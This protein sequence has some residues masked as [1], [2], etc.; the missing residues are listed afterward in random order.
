MVGPHPLA[1]EAGGLEREELAFL[2]ASQVMLLLPLSDIHTSRATAEDYLNTW[3]ETRRQPNKQ[4]NKTL[5]ISMFIAPSILKPLSWLL[6][7]PNNN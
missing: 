6:F 4:T 3:P 1:A 5:I 7:P 2:T